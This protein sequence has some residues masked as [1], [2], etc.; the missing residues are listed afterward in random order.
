MSVGLVQLVQSDAAAEDLRKR[1]EQIE[2]HAVASRIKRQEDDAPGMQ[3]LLV[4]SNAT[5]EDLASTRE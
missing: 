2:S 4:Q 5:A 1:V 3:A